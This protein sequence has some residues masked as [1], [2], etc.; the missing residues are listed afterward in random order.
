[1]LSIEEM[2]KLVNIS[3]KYSYFQIEIKDNGIGFDQRLEKQLF[4]A[5]RRLHSQEKYTGTGIGLALCKKIVNNHHGEISAKSKGNEGSV[6]RVIL[7]FDE[8]K[9]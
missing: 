5:F 1:M 8:V 2:A 4:L 3:P 9:V 7:P 6:F